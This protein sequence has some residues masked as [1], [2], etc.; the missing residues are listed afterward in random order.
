MVLIYRNASSNHQNLFKKQKNKNNGWW[1][2]KW[3]KI[4]KNGPSKLVK[5]FK[6]K[7]LP[8]TKFNSSTNFYLVH[9]WILFPKWSTALY[10]TQINIKYLPHITSFQNFLSISKNPVFIFT[11]TFAGFYTTVSFSIHDL[12][13]WTLAP[14]HTFCLAWAAWV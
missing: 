2:I 8:S 7:R 1:R 3:G 9:S 12:T 4:I 11:T 6:S 10:F 5:R 14:F 13:S